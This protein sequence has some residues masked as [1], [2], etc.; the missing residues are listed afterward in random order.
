[1]PLTSH[2]ESQQR[3]PANCL[4]RHCYSYH[5]KPTGALWNL[6]AKTSTGVGCCWKSLK[7]SD[8]H[9]RPCMLAQHCRTRRLQ[10]TGEPEKPSLPPAVSLQRPLLTK[11]TWAWCQLARDG[12]FTLPSRQW[13]MDLETRGNTF[14]GRSFC[15]EIYW[16]M[17]NAIYW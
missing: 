9:W 16:K 13:K 8:L 4:G 11:H 5:W 7:V 2:V 17:R 1:M 15:S 12:C 6:I 10:C 14:R 3:W